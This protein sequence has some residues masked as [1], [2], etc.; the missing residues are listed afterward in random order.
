MIVIVETIEVE[1]EIYE[2]RMRLYSWI[3]DEIEI[4]PK[5]IEQII[6]HKGKQLPINI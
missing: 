5:S 4:Q 1:N 2:S 3:Y 6:H